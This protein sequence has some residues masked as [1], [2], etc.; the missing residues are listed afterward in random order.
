MKNYPACKELNRSI[1][2]CRNTTRL[3]YQTSA[4]VQTKFRVTLLILHY[5]HILHTLNFFYPRC[6]SN[7]GE[8]IRFNSI[9]L[10]IWPLLCG[11][12]I[13]FFIGGRGWGH[14]KEGKHCHILS[15]MEPNIAPKE[16]QKIPCTIDASI[17]YPQH[18]IFVWFD[19]LIP[20]NNFSAM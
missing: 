9:T 12:T 10:R 5:M 4:W 1:K 18:Y 17:Q 19:S 13:F 7:S 15:W 6:C 20:A 11:V 16:R 2:C 3:W 8:F 14:L